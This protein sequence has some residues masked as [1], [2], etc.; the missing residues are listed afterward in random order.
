MSDFTNITIDLKPISCP[1]MYMIK[2]SKSKKSKKILQL[3]Y[4]EKYQYEIGIDEAGRGPMFGRLYVAGVILPKDG[5]IDFAKVRDSKKISEK[6]RKEMSEYIKTHALSYH[7]YYAEAS[8]ID[9]IN[10]R[11]AVLKGM[12][13]CALKNIE[14]IQKQNEDGEPIALDK[15]FVMVDGN[16]FPPL[17]VYDDNTSTLNNVPH[18]T[19]VGG[20]NT[21]TNI[22]A[23]SILAKVA[24][25]EY[26]KDLCEKKPLLKSLYGLDKNMGYGTKQHLEAIAIYG[27]TSEHRRSY[28][29]CKTALLSKLQEL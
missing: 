10:I 1:P 29:I 26:I 20:D 8:E 13:E 23:A 27:I 9:K 16:D 18:D 25:D 2:Q 14:N 5:S 24:R 17:M 6:K 7:I 28:G 12:K 11:E 19:F 22:A 15:F 4:D 21:Y 3:S